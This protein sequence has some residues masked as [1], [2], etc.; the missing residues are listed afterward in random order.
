MN[1]ITIVLLMICALVLT[2]CSHTGNVTSDTASDSNKENVADTASATDTV[3]TVETAND[4]GK[5][6]SIS[7][8]KNADNL[9]KTYTVKGKVLRTMQQGVISG[10]RIADSSDNMP[11]QSQTMPAVNS[12]VTV[13]GVLKTSSYFGYYLAEIVD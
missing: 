7:S 2:A 13:T 11:I 1:K 5:I 8:I 9:G 4:A 6:V 12:T 10:Y 3:N